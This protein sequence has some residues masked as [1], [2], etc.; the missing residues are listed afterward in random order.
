MK[1]NELLAFYN[2][3]VAVNH[4]VT[5]RF[6]QR[7]RTLNAV[8]AHEILLFLRGIIQVRL[9]KPP[10]LV[11][12]LLSTAA[13]SGSTFIFLSTARIHSR[14]ITTDYRAQKKN[15]EGVPSD[16]APPQSLTLT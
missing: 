16:G 13:Q 4:A 7:Y 1:I 10:E 14:G 5:G 6:L 8:I 15:Y 9:S 3:H 2:E 11:E 12:S